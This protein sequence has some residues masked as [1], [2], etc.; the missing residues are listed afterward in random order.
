MKIW[1]YFQ[2]YK[3]FY[4]CEKHEKVLKNFEKK[5]EFWFRKKNLGF[6]TDTE[7]GPWFWF[8]IPKPG[9]GRTLQRC[10]RSVDLINL[11]F[12]ALFSSFS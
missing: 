9:F 3:N 7:I 5:K 10:I 11:N 4:V 12:L 6:D 8:S 2:A 1:V